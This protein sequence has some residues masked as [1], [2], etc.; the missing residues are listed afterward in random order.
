[1]TRPRFRYSAIDGLGRKTSGVLAADS[2]GAAHQA[3]RERG[4]SPVR[5]TRA[6]LAGTPRLKSRELIE[7]LRAFGILLSA[8]V[9]L[10]ASLEMVAA[11]DQ[12]GGRLAGE[13]LA[14]V[15]GGRELAPALGEILGPRAAHLP[16]LAAAGQAA[17]DLG[18]ALQQ[19][20]DQLQ[21]DVK[22][23]E[24]FQA[25]LSYPVFIFAASIVAVGLLMT[26]VIPSIA[27]LVAQGDGEAPL[28]LGVLLAAS[29]ATTQFGP[30]VLV[31]GTAALI[32]LAVAARFGLL[33][34]LADQALLDGPFGVVFRSLWFGRFSAILGRL[35]AAGVAAPEA[36]G[37]AALGLNNRLARSRVNETVQNLFAGERVS[38]AL[39]SC[40]GMPA[41]IGRMALVGEESGRLGEMLHDAGRIEQRRAVEILRTASRWLAPALII[42]MGVL[43]GGIM[44][45][46]L[47]AVLS[48]GETVLD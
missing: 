5:I 25:A 28:L 29:R 8:G 19:A 12:S 15:S 47:G 4:F 6:W 30:A 23:V 35:L 44:A 42:A 20:A 1:V 14:E 33:R 46:L 48:V 40:P 9:P 37:L 13:L 32:G 24:E 16:G 11:N 39:A 27:P 21:E 43:I 31:G 34:A 7:F 17:G 2:E 3:L 22:I 38:S 36:F 18:G 26:F 45:T 10:A 41:A